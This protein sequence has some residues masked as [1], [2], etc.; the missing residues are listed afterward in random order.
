MAAGPVQDLIL[1]VPRSR[2]CSR[3][4][5]ERYASVM[6]RACEKRARSIS[7]EPFARA[8]ELFVVPKSMPIASVPMLD[9]AQGEPSLSLQE[10]ALSCH[11]GAN[12]QSVSS[13]RKTH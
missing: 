13:D 2:I 8:I 9:V 6:P 5:N 10:T 11:G 4:N 1:L 3:Y 12:Q 7:P